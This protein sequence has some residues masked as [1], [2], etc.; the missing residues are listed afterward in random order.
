MIFGT[1]GVGLIME[2]LAS[3]GFDQNTLVMYSSDNGI[4]FTRGRTNFYDP[5]IAEPLLISSPL[6]QERWG[7]VQMMI[8]IVKLKN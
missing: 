8:F 5:G 4:P 3:A 2:E 7:Q 6:H 1:L